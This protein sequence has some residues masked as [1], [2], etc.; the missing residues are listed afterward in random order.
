MT[1][2][3]YA[4]PTDDQIAWRDTGC[5]PT[6]MPAH[7][8]AF[9]QCV[10][11]V[12]LGAR[13]PQGRP[14]VGAGVACRVSDGMD[15]RIL[16]SRRANATLIAVVEAGS[17]IAATFS[18]ARDHR[19]IQLKAPGARIRDPLPD[20]ASEAARQAALLADDLVELGYS[21][22]QAAVYAWVGTADLASL[23]F[24]PER[25]FTQTPGP[26]AGSELAR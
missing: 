16:L 5:G 2:T 19:S 22:S 7:L 14:V 8:V 26:G 3:F 23:D 17:A 9:L 25:F 10:V 12:T 15:V 24:R 6:L 1:S 21:K 13:T 11:A 18:R 20:D 4:T